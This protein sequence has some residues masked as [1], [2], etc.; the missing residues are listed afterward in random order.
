MKLNK[1]VLLTGFEPFGEFKINPSWETARKIHNQTISN[2]LI[3]SIQVPLAYG[4]IKPM[5]IKLIEDFKPKI[6][7]NLGQSY[8]NLI[9]LE[10]V[11]INLADLTESNILYNCKSQPKDEILEPKGPSSYFASLPLRIILNT[12]R[13]NNIPSE[14]S[15]TAG[16]FGCNQIFYNTMHKVHQ[17]KLPIKAGFI[18][19]PCLPSQAAELQRIKKGKIPSM[20]I[21]I[22]VKALKLTIKETISSLKA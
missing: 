2:F 12:L 21:K 19:V 8:R 9:S 11:A 4:K 10:K 17:T 14:I 13:Q 3:K 6:I 7:I 16:T 5:T 18:H 1:I 20:D 15:Y 22:I